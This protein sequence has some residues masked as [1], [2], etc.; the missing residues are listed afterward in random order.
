VKR[1]RGFGDKI[2]RDFF[3]GV[4]PYDILKPGDKVLEIGC[5]KGRTAVE[6]ACK[7]RIEA[8]GVDL[9]DYRIPEPIPKNTIIWG[10]GEPTINIATDPLTFRVGNAV[11]LPYQNGEFDFVFSFMVFRY[12]AN[13]LL[14][15]NEAHR[16]LKQGGTGVIDLACTNMVPDDDPAIKPDIETLLMFLPHNHQL[17]Y[18]KV[19]VDDHDADKSL[20]CHRVTIRKNSDKLIDVPAILNKP[21]L[22]FYRMS[23]RTIYDESGFVW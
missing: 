4:D 21:Q 12:I 13:K 1:D 5:G 10:G 23:T 8:H 16:V 15:L 7:L 20:L 17:T 14:A 18:D 9:K 22:D 19:P 3:E 2:V 11:E 6:M